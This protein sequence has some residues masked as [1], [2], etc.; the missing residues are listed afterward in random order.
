M[1]SS[2]GIRYRRR[3]SFLRLPRRFRIFGVYLRSHYEV[4]YSTWKDCG[5]IFLYKMLLFM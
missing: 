4:A 1:K 2:S 3:L 5:C